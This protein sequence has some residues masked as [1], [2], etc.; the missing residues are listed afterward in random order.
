MYLTKLKPMV[1]CSGLGNVIEPTVVI[2][3]ASDYLA[4]V[5]KTLA[6]CVLY[7]ENQKVGALNIFRQE[8]LHGITMFSRNG[9]S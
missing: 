8:E 3:S 4:E 2:M 7:K 5:D 9:C 6:Q 1:E